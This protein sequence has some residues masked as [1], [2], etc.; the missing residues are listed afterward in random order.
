MAVVNLMQVGAVKKN[1]LFFGAGGGLLPSLGLAF[2][3]EFDAMLAWWMVIILLLPPLIWA[4]KTRYV[5]L[6]SICSIAFATQFITVPFFYLNRDEFAW[7]H[8]KPFGFTAWEASPMLAKVSFFLFTLIVF[9]RWFY[10][11]SFMGGA[12][13]NLTA[14]PSLSW[15]PKISGRLPQKLNTSLR[16]YRKA[17]LFDLFIIL[18]VT[19]M[20]PLNLWMFT[21]GISLVGVE[22]PNLPYKLSGLL[23]YLTKYFIPLF[24]GYLYWKTKRGFFTMLLLL[25]YAFVLGLTSVSRSALVLVM[26]PVLTLAW[27][28]RRPLLIFVAALGTLLGFSIVS[29]SRNFVH[30]VIDGKTG[31]LTDSGIDTIL[32]RI[33]SDSDSRLREFD[34]H[35]R[36]LIG[37]FERVDGFSNLVMSQYYNPNEVIG[38]FGYI[39]RMINRSLAPMEQDLHHMQWQGFVLPE[40]FVNCGALLSNAVIVGNAGLWWILI[41]AIVAA[42]TLVICEKSTKRVIKRYKAPE[43]LSSAIICFLSMTYFIE[44]GGSEVFLYPFVML[45]IASWLPPLNGSNKQHLLLRTGS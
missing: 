20:V 16:T 19:A 7:G 11:F 15:A 4:L 2:A 23:H 9:F 36:T 34:Y 18:V 25:S 45:F 32:L 22:S 26:L 39:L 33:I 30:I 42:V 27:L 10:G 37:I 43:L 24:L 40:G 1:T 14:K 5:A 3:G 28:D 41:S 8:I 38:T 31:A 29:L 6:I 17:W 44:T 21:Q 35:F 12:P 13:R